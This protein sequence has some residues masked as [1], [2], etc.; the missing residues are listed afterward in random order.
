[1]TERAVTG[2]T[3]ALDA[4][5]PLAAFRQRFQLPQG[6]GG[7]SAIYLCGNSL[8]PQ[9]R[10]ARERVAALLDAWAELG[11]R[12]H[13]EGQSPWLHYH[14]QF[15]A[16]LARLVGAE[17]SEVVTMNTLTV[18]LHLMLVSFY[19]PTAAR[20]RVLI[21]KGAFPSDRYALSSQLR[22]HGYAP[23]QAL[24]EVGPRPGEA[25]LR[26]EDL[27]AAIE[28]ERGTLALVMLPG[29]H[30]LTGQALDIAVLTAAARAAGAS[31]GWDLAHAVGNLPLALHDSGADFAVWCSYKYL[32]GG[33][34]AIAGAF[35]HARHAAAA[36]LPRFAGWWGHDAATR[37]AMG[38]DFVPMDGAEGWQ[39]SNP[40]V[41]A[42][43][44]LAAALELFDA[45]GMAA[46][47]AKSLALGA[48]ARRLLEARCGRGVQIL[49]PA[50]D[51]ARGCQLSLRVAGQ[52]D[53]GPRVYARL[54]AAGVIGDWRAPDVIR[55]APAP[56]YN[57]YADVDRAA[58]ALA[59][60]LAEP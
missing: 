41:L 11:V 9:P 22:Y 38:P 59:A 25:L 54:T 47:R 4:G 21:E 29:V 8:G 43:A 53:A 49:P 31:V 42:L 27:V 17:P 14:E 6:P 56:L 13:E 34:G 1:M 28:R 60:A 10:A 32:C 35:V 40:P 52:P 58:T 55:L 39:L 2:E 48:Y 24:I 23:E 16:P 37:F 30:Y 26:T 20:H 51:A 7:H 46:L 33:P 18:N 5:D 44:P 36:A 3:R 19:R 15:A 57:S 45:A 50:A 12:G